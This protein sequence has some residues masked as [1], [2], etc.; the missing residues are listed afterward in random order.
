M[1]TRSFQHARDEALLE[2]DRHVQ[3]ER[4]LQRKYDELLNESV[5]LEFQSMDVVSLG[6]FLD[7]DNTKVA[8]K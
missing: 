8:A 1:F 6:L 3:L 2:R 5:P 4:D 7:I